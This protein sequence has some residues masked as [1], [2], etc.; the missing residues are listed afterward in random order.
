MKVLVL[1]LT[2]DQTQHRAD[3]CV[4][5]WIQDI[6]SPHEYHFYGSE[7]QSKTM[8]NTWNCGPRDGEHRLRLPEKTYKMLHK[9]L[10]HEWDFLY[11]CDDDTYL[12][13]N[14]LI[15]FLQPLDHTQDHYI[16]W[17]IEN[18]HAYALGGSGYVLSRSAAVK[19]VDHLR[20]IHNNRVITQGCEDYAVGLSLH[21]QHVKPTHCELFHAP[22]DQQALNDQ[23][24]C[25]RAIKR[26]I[27]THYVQ[28]PTMCQ[29][30][31]FFTKKQCVFT[32]N[33]VYHLFCVNDAIDRFMKTYHKIKKSGLIHKTQAIHVNCVGDNADQWSKQISKLEKITTH[34]ND[35]DRNESTSV[36]LAKCVAK[37]NPSGNTLYLH[38]K[39]ASNKF[40]TDHEKQCVNQWVD[41]MEHHLIDKYEECLSLLRRYRTCG[42]NMANTNGAT[43]N[44]PDTWHYSG[45]FWWSQNWYLNNIPPCEDD[46]LWPEARFISAGSGKDESQHMNIKTSQYVYP[47][48]LYNKH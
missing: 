27:S 5:T 6:N 14:K 8:S 18:P 44:L 32:N 20:T 2:C 29:I 12:R 9:S 3:T 23:T 7:N 26:S 39:G 34:K 45:N 21:E 10:E 19:C 40:N 35:N 38:S 43:W 41:F 16:G 48:I 42:C 22:T 46:Y 47:E 24:T 13:V 36:N 25:L 15:N 37:T 4:N 11:K 33:I 31:D 1:I 30:H 17:V 28:P